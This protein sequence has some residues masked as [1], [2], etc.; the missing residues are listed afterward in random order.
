MSE[1]REQINVRTP[2]EMKQRWA[3]WIDD[4]SNPH[5]TYNDLVR[6]AVEEY[7]NRDEGVA[8]DAKESTAVADEIRKLR[9]SIERLEEQFDEID[10]LDQNDVEDSVDS[11][12]RQVLYT[13][14]L[15]NENVEGI[16]LN[17]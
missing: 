6:T 8:S 2:P 7:I 4:E 13:V 15:N 10:P 5:N 11:K 12:V 14:L 1:E 3:D 16:E 9:R 17:Q